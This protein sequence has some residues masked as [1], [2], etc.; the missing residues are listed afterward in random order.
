MRCEHIFRSGPRKGE[1]C[2]VIPKN[3]TKCYPHAKRSVKYK[4]VQCTHIFVKG[5][6]K[7]TQ[8]KT[9]TK[10]GDKC[11]Y[12]TETRIASNIKHNKVW[13][14][15]NSEKYA[16]SLR[17]HRAE[18]KAINKERNRKCWQRILLKSCKGHDKRDNREFNLNVEWIN[19]MLDK[20]GGYCYHCEGILD[21]TNG[22]KQPDQVS[23]DRV[24]NSIG[25][26]MGN[27]VLSCLICNLKKGKK[28]FSEFGSSENNVLKP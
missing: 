3:G 21:L 9:M 11:F 1:R 2:D 20:Q 13:R 7:D 17:K 19:L 27:V 10:L 25:H 5:K 4:I 12:H 26:I 22:D 16:E 15:N 23:I 28:S 24:D 6:K 14:E 18:N 8:C